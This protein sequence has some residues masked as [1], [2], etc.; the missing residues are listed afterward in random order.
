M[1]G[2][3]RIRLLGPPFL[4]TSAR[5]IALSRR[6]SLALLAW[7]AVK[8]PQRRD[9]AAALLWPESGGASARTNLRSAIFDINTASDAEILALSDDSIGLVP[10]RVDLD[11][12][13]FE[14]AMASCPR[15]RRSACCG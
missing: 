4:E 7:I 11:H 5:R 15:C 6:K 1:L 13:A 14:A 2:I 12:A 10:D 3:V 9:S 8:G